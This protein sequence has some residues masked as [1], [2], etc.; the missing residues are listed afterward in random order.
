MYAGRGWKSLEHLTK[1]VHRDNIEIQ[2][3]NYKLLSKLMKFVSILNILLVKCTVT[4]F[5][6]Y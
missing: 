2:E 6:W 5:L 1:K 3:S 4:V